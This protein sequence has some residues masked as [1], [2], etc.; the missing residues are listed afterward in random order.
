[1]TVDDVRSGVR[2]PDAIA[3]TAWSIELHDRSDGHLWPPFSNDHV[4]YVPLASLTHPDIDN[5]VAAGRCEQKS[6]R[7]LV[8][9]RVADKAGLGQKISRRRHGNR[10]FPY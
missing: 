5:L 3:R 6:E 8:K 2:F 4:H 10:H 9:T 7:K 1:M